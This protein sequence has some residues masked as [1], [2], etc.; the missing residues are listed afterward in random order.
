MTAG[1]SMSRWRKLFERLQGTVPGWRARAVDRFHDSDPRR[2]LLLTAA[3]RLY[4]VTDRRSRC[5]ARRPSSRALDHRALASRRH[6]RRG[7][8]VALFEAFASPPLLLIDARRAKRCMD[9]GL[10]GGGLAGLERIPVVAGSFLVAVVVQAAT[11]IAAA[12]ACWRALPLARAFSGGMLQTALVLVGLSFAIRR[13]RSSGR[14]TCAVVSSCGD[15]PSS[16]T[17]PA[18]GHR[19][20]SMFV[21][22]RQPTGERLAG[23]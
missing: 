1:W 3:A 18:S 13:P 2:A 7:S 19:M 21:L 8:S 15:A 12:F 20:V 14:V 22:V 4:P 17:A 9:G 16:R 5:P 11:G 10:F 23:G 6:R